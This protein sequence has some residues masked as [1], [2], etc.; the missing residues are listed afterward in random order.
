MMNVCFSLVRV[1]AGDNNWVNAISV[2]DEVMLLSDTALMMRLDLQ[3]MAQ[4]GR[5]GNTAERGHR[6][7]THRRAR[8]PRTPLKR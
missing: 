1:T 4:P 2:G 5:K 6:T 3:T 8:L 7:L